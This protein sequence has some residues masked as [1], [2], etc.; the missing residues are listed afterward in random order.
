MKKVFTITIM[1]A[2]LCTAFLASGVHAFA[3]KKG[4]K[5][6]LDCHK[7]DKK[8]AEVIVKKIV[9][10][11]T[12][13]DIK[14][15]PIKG[16]WQIDVEAGEGKHGSLYLDFSKKF[17]VAGQIVP[18][19]Q[20]GKQPPARKVDLSKIPTENA[21]VVGSKTAAKKVIVFS[22]PDC[23]YCRELHKIIKQIVAKRPDI[24]FEIILNPLP[25]HKEDAFKKAQA[26][27]CSKS[28][29]ML[30]DAFSG[31]T[32]PEP[33]CP[34]D[35]IEKNRELAAKLEFNG[36]PTLVRDDGTVLSGYLPEEKL[37]EWID[38]K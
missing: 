14:A 15:S 21:I 19:D 24:A 8:D 28:T 35:Q 20:L 6:C 18:V 17:L 29:E 27:Q 4:D 37:L 3:P 22:D 12:V 31:K 34:P 30:D 32:V 26:I 10:T 1:L 13:T 7:L 2:L 16:V 23:P 9:P 38:K 5:P 33:T 25:M 36:T 11:G